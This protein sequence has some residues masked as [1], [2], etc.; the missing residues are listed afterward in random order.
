MNNWNLENKFALV[1]GGSKGIGN[2]IIKELSD[3]GATVLFLARDEENN[4]R[5]LS[6]I[7]NEKLNALAGDVTNND[8]R[9]KVIAWI[10]DNWGKLDILVNNAGVNIRKP[11]IEYSPDE[12]QRVLNVNL[13]APF[14]LIKELYPLLKKSGHASIINIASVAGSMDAQTGAPY[15]MSKAGIIQ[16]SRSLAAEWAS[17]RIRVNAVSPWFTETPA[18]SGL[19]SNQERLAAIIARTPEKRVAKDVEIAAAVAFLGMDKSSYIT[20]QNI[21]VDGGATSSIL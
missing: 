4:Q 14:E 8:F 13:I 16:L 1:T 21:I 9:K 5:V 2:A 3:L 10:E 15:G 12:Y 11:S 18:T 19:L 20:G 6:T 17:S 7:G